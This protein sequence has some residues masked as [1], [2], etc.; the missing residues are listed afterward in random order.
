LEELYSENARLREALEDAA[1]MI[2]LFETGDL[3]EDRIV[4]DLRR[5]GR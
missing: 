3:Q 1:I 2:R 5:V 4:A